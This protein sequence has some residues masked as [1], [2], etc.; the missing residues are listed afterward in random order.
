MGIRG[1]L[2]GLLGS[3]GRFFKKGIHERCIFSGSFHG[4]LEG[5]L[6]G[7]YG[8]VNGAFRKDFL[9]GIS[10]LQGFFG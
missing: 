5:A 10:S 9:S 7:L 3:F 2:R 8:V 6:E 4:I 1:L